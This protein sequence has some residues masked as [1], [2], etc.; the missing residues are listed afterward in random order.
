VAGR[1]GGWTDA[2]AQ[3]T[4]VPEHPEEEE[5]PDDHRRRDDQRKDEHGPKQVVVVLEVH[6]EAHDERE[7][8]RGEE[9]QRRRQDHPQGRDIEHAHLDDRDEREDGRDDEVRP[10]GRVGLAG[11]LHV[12]VFGHG[13]L[14]RRG[15]ASSG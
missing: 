14:R 4:V 9:N 13:V 7:L 8:G 11:V 6:V 10:S 1:L 12:G 5:Q 2:G 15:A 3:E